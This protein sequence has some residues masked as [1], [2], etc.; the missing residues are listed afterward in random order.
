MKG[1]QNLAASY[2]VD[3]TNVFF[4]ALFGSSLDEDPESGFFERVLGVGKLELSELEL[5]ALFY[6]TDE[7]DLE[8]SCY[9]LIIISVVGVLRLESNRSKIG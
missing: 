4:S 9:S 5:Q 6:E 1:V 7:E 2:G 3:I 8:V